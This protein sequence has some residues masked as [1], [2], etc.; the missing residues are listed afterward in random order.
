MGS[1]GSATRV[2]RR[3]SLGFFGML[4]RIAVLITVCFAAVFGVG[5]WVG[6]HFRALEYDGVHVFG[7]GNHCVSIKTKSLASGDNGPAELI[8][9]CLGAQTKLQS[10]FN[11]DLFSDVRPAYVSWEDID[12]DWYRDLVIWKPS[13]LGGLEA[14][15]FVSSMDGQ[16]HVLEIRRQRA[17]SDGFGCW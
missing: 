1:V 17:L 11:A 7:V 13:S 10:S 2:S 3:E 14:S 15:E 9:D 12:Q 5:L 4:N 16:L 6:E 8:I